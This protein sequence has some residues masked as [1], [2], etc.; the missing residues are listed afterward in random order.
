MQNKHICFLTM[1]FEGHNMWHGR[2][3]ICPRPAV[4][5]TQKLPAQQNSVVLKYP[6]DEVK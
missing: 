3:L 5:S 6:A 4:F 2:G 1:Y